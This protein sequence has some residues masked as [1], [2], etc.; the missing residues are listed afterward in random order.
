MILLW[1]LVFLTPI[2]VTH[3][4][5]L[6]TDGEHCQDEQVFVTPYQIMFQVLNF[7][8]LQKRLE[9]LKIN[10]RIPLQVE[11][12]LPF[13]KCSSEKRLNTSGRKL[14]RNTE[15]EEVFLAFLK[16]HFWLQLEPSFSGYMCLLCDT[17]Q[18]FYVE[19]ELWSTGEVPRLFTT[20]ALGPFEKGTLHWMK[21]QDTNESS[22]LKKL[23]ICGFLYFFKDCYIH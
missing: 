1:F 15:Y 22:Y 20:C 5:Q 9:K 19:Q 18:P 8:W 13:R 17:L 23:L 7:T 21:G 11:K 16:T 3:C 12:T 4:T 6:L 14:G 2:F 10:M